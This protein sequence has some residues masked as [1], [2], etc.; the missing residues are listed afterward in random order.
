MRVDEITNHGLDLSTPTPGYVRTPGLHMSA[1]YNAL[2]KELEPKRFASMG[3]PDVTKMSVGT[4]FEE[5]LAIA[6]ADRIL[7]ERPGEFAADQTGR[8]VKIGTPGS[9]IFSPDQFF[10]PDDRD[11]EGGEF[12]ATW[13]SIR[14]GIT[15][16][17]FDKWFVQMKAYGKPLSIRVWRL[18]V[19]FIN[20]DYSYKGQDGGATLK[21]Y[22]VEFTQREL[23]DNWRMLM[24]FA[25]KRGMFEDGWYEQHKLTEGA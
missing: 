18:F 13:M 17:K 21:A 1:I 19:L 12:K 22:R 9:I 15:D 14:N 11:M 23:D 16:P 20:G 4:S 24:R 3:G 25:D 7:G 6:L 5:V 2:F 10:Y 8:T